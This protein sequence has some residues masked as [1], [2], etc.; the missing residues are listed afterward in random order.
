MA[1]IECHNYILT[2]P[3]SSPSLSGFADTH[4]LSSTKQSAYGSLQLVPK[5][6][7]ANEVG[8]PAQVKTRIASHV[9]EIHKDSLQGPYVGLDPFT[10]FHRYK[11]R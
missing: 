10:T 7:V 3:P 8:G 11:N 9:K 4:E 5:N 1:H 2:F 6:S